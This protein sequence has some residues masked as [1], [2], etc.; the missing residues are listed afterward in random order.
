MEREPWRVARQIL[1]LG[2]SVVLDVG[3]RARLDRDEAR[4]AARE[5]GVRVELHDLDVP[6][7]E[8]A[9]VDAPPHD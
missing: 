7:D 6:P 4:E 1:D 5:A 9:L 8:L 3:L 2:V